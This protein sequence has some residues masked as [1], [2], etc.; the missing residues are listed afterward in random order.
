[1]IAMA[2]SHQDETS[3]SHL[4]KEVSE[5]DDRSARKYG[6]KERSEADVKFGAVADNYSSA[7]V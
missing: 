1:M 4:M 2:S 6:E 5:W 7:F 3:G